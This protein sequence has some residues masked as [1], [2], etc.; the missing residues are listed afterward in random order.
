[1][2]GISGWDGAQASSPRLES[3]GITVLRRVDPGRS[4]LSFSVDARWK[5]RY[6]GDSGEDGPLAEKEPRPLPLDFRAHEFFGPNSK[7]GRKKVICDRHFST[8]G[9]GPLRFTN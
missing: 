3:T 8:C 9:I 2:A 5:N 7:P 4:T 6:L 1:M